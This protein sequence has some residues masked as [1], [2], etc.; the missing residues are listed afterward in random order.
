[1]KKKRGL[2]APA[3]NLVVAGQFRQVTVWKP[4]QQA[5]SQIAPVLITR[6]HWRLAMSLAI[7]KRGI[8][9]AVHLAEGGRRR[10]GAVRAPHGAIVKPAAVEDRFV[11]DLLGRFGPKAGY[12]GNGVAKRLVTHRTRLDQPGQGRSADIR[13]IA[14]RGRF[15]EARTDAPDVCSQRRP[16]SSTGQAAAFRPSGGINYF[17]GIG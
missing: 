2:D 7:T 14:M 9:P 13:G 1:M 11:V 16:S 3:S 17:S 12:I 6:V 4:S 5:W 10:L 8:S 15:A